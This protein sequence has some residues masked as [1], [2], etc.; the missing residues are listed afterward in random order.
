[1]VF[2]KDAIEQ[3]IAEG[4]ENSVAERCD[5]YDKPQDRCP[6]RPCD[7]C[8]CLRVR[9]RRLPWCKKIFF[10]ESKQPKTEDT[11]RCLNELAILARPVEP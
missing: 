1:M 5:G 4:F 7:G 2:I 8:A 10:E 6:M 11:L 3:G 9:W